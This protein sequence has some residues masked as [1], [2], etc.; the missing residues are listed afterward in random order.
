[1]DE[2]FRSRLPTSL[3]MSDE[4]NGHLGVLNGIPT[5]TERKRRKAIRENAADQLTSFLLLFFEI[6]KTQSAKKLC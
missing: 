2:S 6:C 3:D 1:M 4:I 5:Y